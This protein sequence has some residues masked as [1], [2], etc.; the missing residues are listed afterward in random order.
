M[1]GAARILVV[2]FV[3]L[4][5]VAPSRSSYAA[6]HAGILSPEWPLKQLPGKL[7]KFDQNFRKPAE[8]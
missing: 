6:V 4:D 1:L 7:T 5:V 8:A 3:V 2:G